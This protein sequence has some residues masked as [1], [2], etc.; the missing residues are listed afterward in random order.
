MN[1]PGRIIKRGEKDPAIVK[2][3]QQRLNDMGFGPLKV[4][5]EFGKVTE[6]VVKDFQSLTRDAN[7]IP[8]KI[9][10]ELG[11][12][13]WSALFAVNVG[14]PDPEIPVPEW[15]LRAV[16][17]AKSQVGVRE[18][19]PGSNRGKQVEQYLRRAGCNPGDPWCASFVYWCFDEAAKTTGR[20]NPLP[21]TGSCM[22]HWFQTR[23]RKITARQ[24][25][26]NP[27]LIRP[28]TLFIM[29]HG[30][31]RGHTGIVTLSGDGYIST[32]EGN[33]NIGGS[34]EGLMVTELNRKI[35]T[36]SA[37]FIDYSDLEE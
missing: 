12:I 11:A 4:D 30:S 9:D 36:I 13:S 28:G 16:A 26:R 20:S 37:G 22:T 33:S 10:G 35:N 14:V 5:G 2:A 8:L 17:L 1:Y 19:P 27:S 3:V 29:D 18:D 6:S 25:R 31:G 15:I 23:G 24:A 32:I 34:R 21:R 7:Q